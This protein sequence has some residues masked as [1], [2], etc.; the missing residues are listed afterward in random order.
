MT[1]LC[2]C[3][4]KR[5]VILCAVIFAGGFSLIAFGLQAGV[6]R[7]GQAVNAAE[8]QK[9]KDKLYMIT[10]AAGN[11]AGPVSEK[12]CPKGISRG[13]VDASGRIPPIRLIFSE[14][15]FQFA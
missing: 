10:G 1:F 7:C 15:I 9:V 8:I 11:T 6:P 3:L 2:G 13:C 14:T 12:D 5:A 4:R